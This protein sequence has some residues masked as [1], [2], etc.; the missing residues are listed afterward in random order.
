MAI[1]VQIY[2]N[3]NSSSKSISF[4][5]VGDILAPDDVPANAACQ[6]FYFKITAGG[7]QDNNVAFP[8][9][10]VRSLSDLAL[11]KP[12]D[13][14]VERKHSEAPD[15]NVAYVD[16]KSMIIDY[17]YDYINGHTADQFSSGCTLQRPMKF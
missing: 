16:I 12:G 6:S 1:S 10:I 14:T 13:I 5:F 3:A 4:D 8:V 15:S 2:S 9:K 11:F 7:T 17:V